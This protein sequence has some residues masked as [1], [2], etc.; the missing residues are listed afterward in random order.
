[1]L[2]SVTGFVWLCRGM[3]SDK[4]EPGCMALGRGRVGSSR[5]WG[6]C[7]GFDSVI[8]RAYDAAYAHAMLVST[9]FAMLVSAYWGGH[10][11][12]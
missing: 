8:G 10:A 9:H 7:E 11:I 6:R 1:M 5:Q 12:S 3:C 2:R 4:V